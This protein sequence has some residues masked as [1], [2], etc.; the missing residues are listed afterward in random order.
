[1]E[2]NEAIKELEAE[3]KLSVGYVELKY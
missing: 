1:M 2:L 3:G